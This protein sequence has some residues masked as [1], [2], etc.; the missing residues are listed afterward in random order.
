M[1]HARMLLLLLTIIQFGLCQG[2]VYSN[3]AADVLKEAQDHK[4]LEAKQQLADLNLS[5]SAKPL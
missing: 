2:E 3:P 4:A 1:N 5:F